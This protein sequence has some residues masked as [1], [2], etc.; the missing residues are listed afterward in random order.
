MEVEVGAV[1]RKKRRVGMCVG[2][3]VAR[4]SR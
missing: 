4:S 3:A 2:I 1:V